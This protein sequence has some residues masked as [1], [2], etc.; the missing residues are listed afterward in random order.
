MSGLRIAMIAPFGIRPKGTLSARMLPLARELQQR[1]HAVRIVAPAYLNPADAATTA[2]IDG[3]IVEHVRLPRLPEPL[4]ALE[5]ARDLWLAAQRW[6][7]DLLHLFKPKG[8]GG[9]TALL[10][11]AARPTLP[12]LV[13]TDDWEGWGGWNDLAPY[14]RP[15]KTL[16]AWQERTLPRLA[17]A[18]TVASRT[19]QTQVWGFGVPAERVWYVPNGAPAQPPLLPDRDAARARLGLGDEPIVLL[20]TR[21]WE[22]DLREIVAVLLGL[23]AQRPAARL[24]VIGA[25][26]RGEEQELA[27]LAQRAGVGEQLDQRGWSDQATIAA[28]FAAADVALAP[29]ADTL[30][31]RAKGM[32]KLIQ[33]LHAGLPVVASRVGQAAE[34]IVHGQSGLLVPPENGGAL[35]RATL[36]LLA[37]P[38]WARS[39]GQAAQRRVIAELSWPLLAT[40]LEQACL[41]VAR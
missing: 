21:F 30:M 2:T 39:L 20:Y 38:A 5:T 33:L 22:Y 40:T 37:D 36:A 18:V 29:F 7:P 41:A 32:A 13:D 28:S 16:F 19:L 25:G 35:A 11:R 26:E 3:V 1:G 9:L 8:Y 23:R 31:N 14:S 17:A 12:L 27:R 24:L 4:S 10:A 6:Q 34:Y 15:M